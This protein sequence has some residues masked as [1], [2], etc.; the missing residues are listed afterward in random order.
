LTRLQRRTHTAAH[1]V[2]LDVSEHVDGDLMVVQ[3]VHVVEHHTYFVI[4]GAF[5]IRIHAQAVGEIGRPAPLIEIGNRSEWRRI[6]IGVVAVRGTPR[7]HLLDP[8]W[9]RV[10]VE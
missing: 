8:P 5:Q 4:P 2:E 7:I 9:R 3:V 6:R 1:P 10:A